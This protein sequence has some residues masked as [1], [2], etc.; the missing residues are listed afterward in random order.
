MANLD[1]AK[2]FSPLRNPYGNE[3][4]CEEFTAAA[5]NVI[6]PGQILFQ[7]ASGLVRVWSGTATGYQQ[8]VGAALGF[9]TAADADRKIL[10]AHAPDQEYEVQTDDNTCTVVA[11]CVGANF[12]GTNLTSVSTTRGISIAELDGST[13]TTVNTSTTIA[14]FRCIRISRAIE[15]SDVSTSWTRVVVRINDANHYLSAN[16]GV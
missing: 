13:A 1:G 5:T 15:G 3:I 12:E 4:P 16:A 11:D 10:V 2:G 9:K 8:L 6:Y 7:N 14:P